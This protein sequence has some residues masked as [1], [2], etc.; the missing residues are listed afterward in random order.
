MIN[1]FR[2]KKN[3]ERK[4]ALKIYKWYKQRK[5]INESIENKEKLDNCKKIYKWYNERKRIKDLKN[6]ENI[7]QL[8]LSKHY[9]GKKQKEIYKKEINH[10]HKENDAQIKIQK[11][12]RLFLNK[13]RYRLIKKNTILIQSIIRMYLSKLKFKKMCK[14]IIIIQSL[15]RKI[16]YKN[17]YSKIL[18]CR[19]IVND[20]Y[21]NL[22]NKIDEMC[23]IKL[24]ITL[25]KIYRGKVNLYIINR[26]QG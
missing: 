3:L 18:Y 17:K 14:S 5:Y 20:I 16:I 15:I 26:K 21:N 10:I 4:Y 23:K 1:I 9:R 12:G 2:N 11:Y 19:N 25:Q 24:V 22:I 8:F 7:I 13:Y 6:K